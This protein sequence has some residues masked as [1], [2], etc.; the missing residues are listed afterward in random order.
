MVKFISYDGEYPNLCSG[1]L[2]LEID[3]KVVT[4]GNTFKGTD[5]CA[6]WRSG[7]CCGFRGGNYS[8]S[9]IETDE[10]QFDDVEYFPEECLEYYDEIKR[11]FNSNVPYGCC[12]GCI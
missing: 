8:D 1:I 6:F 9:Y 3:G 2:T 4:F 5:Y 12:G 10:W 7:G 11:L